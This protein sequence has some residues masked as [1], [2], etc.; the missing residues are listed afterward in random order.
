[1]TGW[2]WRG[3]V[4]LL[5]VAVAFVIYPMIEG[6]NDVINSD[7]PAFATGAR[8]LVSDPGH[9]YDIEL[10]RRV[11]FEVTGGRTLITLGIQGI[12]PFLAPAWVAL[13]AVPFD[14]LG[15]NLGGR[16]WILFG[17]ASLALGLLLAVRPR[18]PSAILPAFA[19]VPTALLLLNAQ[20]DGLVALGVGAAI[21]L[22]SKPYLAGLSLGLTL[23]KP[24]LVVPIGLALL[25]TRM[26]RVVVGW[27][28]AGLLLLASTLILNPHWVVDWL[29]SAGSTVQAGSREVD[30]AHFGVLFP[31]GGQ[32]FAEVGLAL[33]AMVAVMVVAWRRRAD[34]RAAAAVVV[35]GGVLAA[36]HALPT[37]LVLVA[38][39]LAIW[40]KA[41]W[42]DWLLLSVGTAIA[43]FT[44]VPIP[45]VAGVL[46]IGWVLLRAGGTLTWLRREPVPLSTG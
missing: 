4:A 46:T 8:I 14:L 5:A 18:P 10:Q 21:A 13:I 1:L 23:V 2:R 11:Q 41:Q 30:V 15:T 31:A 36:L 32:A 37:D 39:A 12:L 42:Y 43:A 17:L 9:L 33:A 20:L 34:L 29:K 22:R 27:V 35:A 40:G 45:T 25:V 38:L 24:H 26:W 28:A 19:S 44:P 7:W 16:V 3:S 6:E